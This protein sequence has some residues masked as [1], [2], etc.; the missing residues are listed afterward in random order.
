MVGSGVVIVSRLA[1]IVDDDMRWR[2]EGAYQLNHLFSLR[3]V[4]ALLAFDDERRTLAFIQEL[5]FAVSMLSDDEL[6][7]A[8]SE[9]ATYMDPIVDVGSVIDFCEWQQRN[10]SANAAEHF[11]RFAVGGAFTTPGEK[12]HLYVSH[13]R[14]RLVEASA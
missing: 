2:L 5:F 10:F 6:N 4:G 14:A 3:I 11:G 8:V 12:L 13:V 7:T 9:D 1:H